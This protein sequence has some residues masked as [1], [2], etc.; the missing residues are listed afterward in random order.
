ARNMEMRRQMP[1]AGPLPGGVPVSL[2]AVALAKAGPHRLPAVASAKAGPPTP[3]PGLKD[4][5]GQSRPIKL[6]FMFTPPQPRLFLRLFVAIQQNC[7]SMN[8]LRLKQSLCNRAQSC[9]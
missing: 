7:L 5:Q 2:P 9:P 3:P 1:A 4:R 6:L 8:N